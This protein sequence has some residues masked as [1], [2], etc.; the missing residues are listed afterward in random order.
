MK[1]KKM[2]SEAEKSS[3]SRRSLHMGDIKHFNVDSISSICKES[4]LYINV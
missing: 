1:S 3:E 2:G 4:I